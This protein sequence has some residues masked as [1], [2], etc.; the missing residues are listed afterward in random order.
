MTSDLC[1]AGAVLHQSS[2]QANWELVVMWVRIPVQAIIIQIFL[3]AAKAVLK[4]DNQIHSLLFFS[5]TAR[6]I[7]SY[8]TNL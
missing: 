4:C 6:D 3:A 1:D 5:F 8:E 7:G 2:Y